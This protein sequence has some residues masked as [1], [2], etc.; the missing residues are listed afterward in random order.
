[1]GTW[2]WD[3]NTFV[4]NEATNLVG[5]GTMTPQYALQIND[6]TSNLGFVVNNAGSVTAARITVSDLGT[7]TAGFLSIGTITAEAGVHGTTTVHMPAG[8]NVSLAR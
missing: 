3:D 6:G 5:I 4:V 7:L 1:M 2:R 8:L